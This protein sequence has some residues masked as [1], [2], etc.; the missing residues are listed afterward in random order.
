MISIYELPHYHLFPYLFPTPLPSLFSL[1]LSLSLCFLVSSVMVRHISCH[2]T[3]SA[4]QI[5]WFSIINSL[6]TVL[7]LSGITAIIIVRTLNRDIAR[8]NEED[9]VW[10]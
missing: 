8:Y 7:F 6:I 9:E 10:T 1:S 5:H 4:Q 3:S 2:M